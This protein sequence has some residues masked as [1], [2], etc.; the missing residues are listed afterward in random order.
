MDRRQAREKTVP[1]LEKMPQ[2]ADRIP[3]AD[4]AVAVRHH[5]TV[6]ADVFFVIDV[7]VLQPFS[8]EIRGFRVKGIEPS[9]TG[10]PG[11]HGAVEDLIAEVKAAGYIFRVADAEGMD[12]ELPRD[13]AAGVFQNVIEQVALRIQRPAA[14]SV[15]VKTDLQEFFSAAFAQFKGTA[16]LDNGEETGRDPVIFL[17]FDDTVEFLAA[18]LRPAD[19]PDD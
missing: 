3:P 16:A 12:R 19:R 17:L 9:V 7:N 1:H 8:A 11:G 18:A 14:E 6:A 2:V 5:R 15:P 13:Q 4:R 10:I